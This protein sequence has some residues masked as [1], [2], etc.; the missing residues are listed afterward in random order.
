LSE[1]KPSEQKGTDRRKFLKY[2]AGV[3]VV[4]AAAAAGYYA[5]QPAPAPPTPTTTAPATTIAPPTPTATTLQFKHGKSVMYLTPDIAETW[6]VA[7]KTYLQR[8]VEADGWKFKFDTSDWS[9]S[10][11]SDQLITYA[12]QYDCIFV[13]PT[14]L[15]GINPAIESAEKEYHCP[16]V[17]IK[18]FITGHARFTIS[19]DD[20]GGGQTLANM[21]IADLQRRFGTTEGKTVVGFQGPYAASG[22]H[23][24]ALGVIDAMKKHPEMKYVEVET[25]TGDP[26][27]WADAADTYFATQTADAVVSGSGGPY[28]Y[29]IMNALS[30]YGRLYYVGDPKHIYSISIDGKPSDLQWIRRGYVDDSL[31]QSPDALMPLGWQLMRDYIVKDPSYQYPP[32][33][34][35]DLPTPMTVTNPPNSYWPPDNNKMLIDKGLIYPQTDMPQGV[36]PVYTVNKDNVNNKDIWG[37]TYTFWRGKEEIQMTEWPAKGTPPAWSKQLLADYEAMFKQ[38][39]QW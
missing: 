10:K 32:Y 11:C 5:L 15:E 27:G 30:R 22:W 16:V 37:N 12:Q 31:S 13:F 6:W 35:P 24:R 33:K 28:W 34:I 19:F 1:K 8:A 36:S 2:G 38:Y 18:N 21:A 20:F 3:V 25:G 7:C 4:A 14:S 23:M 26:A 39:Y 17:A 9:D 29:G